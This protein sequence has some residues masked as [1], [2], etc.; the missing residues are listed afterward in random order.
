MLEVEH[1]HISSKGC[2]CTDDTRRCTDFRNSGPL[3]SPVS[4]WPLAEASGNHPTRR[5]NPSRLLQFLLALV[6]TQRNFYRTLLRNDPDIPKK[7]TVYRFSA[8]PRYNWRRLL[9]MTSVA[10]AQGLGT[11]VSPDRDA[12]FMVD[13]SLFDRS[14]SKKVELLARVYDHVEHVYRKGLRLLM[15]G[16]SGGTTFLPAAFS[17]TSEQ[18]TNRLQPADPRIDKRTV[19][20]PRRRESC[21]KSPDVVLQLLGESQAAGL[22]ARYVLFDSWLAFPRLLRQIVQDRN[23]HVVAMVQAMKTVRYTYEGKRYTLKELYAHV[24]KRPGK[25]RILAVVAV[26]RSGS[27]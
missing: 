23:L 4:R 17:L 26:P 14:R 15:L 5:E 12:V 1:N 22:E 19:G 24:K 9:L 25:A 6:F 11:L 18:A 2:L 8:S 13:D 16:W 7:D 3:F 21:Q 10:I 20:Y 27:P